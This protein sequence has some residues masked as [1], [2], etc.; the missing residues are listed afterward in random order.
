LSHHF[1]IKETKY[2]L[3]AWFKISKSK[4]VKKNGI[5]YDSF[6]ERITGMKKLTLLL[7]VLG[8]SSAALAYDSG[9]ALV[10]EKGTEM[11]VFVNGKLYNKQPGKFV[12]VRSSSGLFHIEVKVM[13]PQN[14]KWYT[15]RKDIRA[16]KGFE[17]QYKVVFINSKPQLIEVK[18]YPI[19]SRYFLNPSLYNRHQTT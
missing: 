11:H 2:S 3:S 12:R 16:Q 8:I 17:L 15:T 13:N 14:K 1:W 10:T 4:S 7:M 6:S 9:I 19:Y 18:K 5:P